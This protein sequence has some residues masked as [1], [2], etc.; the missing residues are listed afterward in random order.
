[1]TIRIIPTIR[2][3]KKLFLL[4]K[5]LIAAF[6]IL[7][8][9]SGNLYSQCCSPG[10]PASTGNLNGQL[11]KGEIQIDATYRYG[12][13]G[14][15]FEGSG[16]SATSFIQNGNFNHLGLAFRIALS[17]KLRAKLSTGYF[18]NKTQNY[19]AGIIPETQIGSGIT[20]LSL[21]LNYL[22]FKSK[23]ESF[24][25]FSGLGVKIPIG[26]NSKKYN[27]VVIPFDLQPT[28]GAIDLN[29]Q[30]S[31]IKQ[32]STTKLTSIFV[33][34]IEIKGK[35]KEAYRYGFFNSSSY[36]LTYTFKNSLFLTTEARYEYRARDSRPS[37][38][39]GIQLSDGR[40]AI[41]VTGSHKFF[42]SGRIGLKINQQWLI[43]AAVDIPVYQYYNSKQLG[44]TVAVGVMIRKYIHP[45]PNKTSIQND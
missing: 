19:A 24:Q 23:N 28:T 34:R 36:Y 5:S 29:H 7:S 30:L 9:L 39:N 33:N 35:N 38:G 3:E 14:T 10:N 13:S 11:D 12:Y 20:D 15:Y 41:Y 16:K 8:T 45:K 22:F 18:I 27:G 44:N 6:L 42:M 26:S 2:L 40:E 31:L 43:S 37:T 1:V 17:N 25:L 32:H 21:D 4:N